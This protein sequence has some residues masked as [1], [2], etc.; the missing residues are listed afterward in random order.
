[1]INYVHKIKYSEKQLKKKLVQRFTIKN[2]INK[3]EWN[4]KKKKPHRAGKESREMKK[5]AQREKIKWQ[6]GTLIY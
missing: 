4:S 5:R 6:T 3:S 2:A 1:M